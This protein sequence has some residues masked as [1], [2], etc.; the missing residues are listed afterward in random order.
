MARFH[1][2]LSVTQGDVSEFHSRRTY[3]P[4][5][6]EPSLASRNVHLVGPRHDDGSLVTYR[7]QFNEEFAPAIER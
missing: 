7:E 4:L 1:L 3:T 2:S 5:S 6:A